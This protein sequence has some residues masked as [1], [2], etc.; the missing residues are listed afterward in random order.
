MHNVTRM[1]CVRK[2]PTTTTRRPRYFKRITIAWISVADIVPC[3][4]RLYKKYKTTPD[5]NR[6]SYVGFTTRVS[7]RF[8]FGKDRRMSDEWCAIA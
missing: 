5:V 6:C 1:Y 4:C 8:R 2:K 3:A 7:F